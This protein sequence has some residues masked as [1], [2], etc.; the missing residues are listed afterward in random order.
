MYGAKPEEMVACS[1]DVST[2]R[3]PAERKL[4]S[5]RDCWKKK[6]GNQA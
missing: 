2:E 1:F 3:K 5:R 6:G 4:D